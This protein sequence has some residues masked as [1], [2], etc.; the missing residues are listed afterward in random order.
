MSFNFMEQPMSFAAAPKLFVNK[1]TT[2]D[3]DKVEEYLRKTEEKSKSLIINQLMDLEEE[4]NYNPKHDYESLNNM[5]IY[6]FVEIAKNVRNYK[7]NKT[8]T[9]KG[10][11]A[12]AKEDSKCD[13]CGNI[14][15]KE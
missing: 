11:G 15:Y 7:I 14:N 3:T 6:E 1:K 12:P 5:S 10:C 4:K 13:Y 9:C 8:F 2:I